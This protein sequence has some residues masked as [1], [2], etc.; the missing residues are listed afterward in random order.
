MKHGMKQHYGL[1]Q[2]NKLA[3]VHKDV[4]VPKK[5]KSKGVGVERTVTFNKKTK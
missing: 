2:H 1:K 4:S 3:P 5:V